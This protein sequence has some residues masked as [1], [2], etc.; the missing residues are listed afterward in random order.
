MDD[1]G[2]DM[3]H[4][5]YGFK[6]ARLVFQPKKLHNSVVHQGLPLLFEKRTPGQMSPVQFSSATF[7]HISSGHIC[8]G[9]FRSSQ[10]GPV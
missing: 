1:G 4:S 10:P 2:G 9:Q 5:Y 3:R 6:S 7:S 8:S